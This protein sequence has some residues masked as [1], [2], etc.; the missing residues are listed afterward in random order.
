MQ[1]SKVKVIYFLI[2][3]LS[4]FPYPLLLYIVFFLSPHYLFN[5]VSPSPL[6]LHI[7]LVLTLS[8]SSY[9]ISSS[10]FY[11]S[12]SHNLFIL[13]FIMLCFQFSDTQRHRTPERVKYGNILIIGL[14]K[15]LRMYQL[16]IR[17][18]E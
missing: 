18:T 12:L 10:S 8:F 4:N 11:R 16:N 3:L 2:Q 14:C 13:R 1:H 9:S 15:L 5:S 7:I 6:S 17:I